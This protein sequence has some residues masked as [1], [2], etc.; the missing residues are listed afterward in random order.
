MIRRPK[1]RGVKRYPVRKAKLSAK[2]PNRNIINHIFDSGFSG[3]N[4]SDSDLRRVFKVSVRQIRACREIINQLATL[5][6]A[7]L[8]KQHALVDIFRAR[9]KPMDKY[10]CLT[11]SF[12]SEAIDAGYRAKDFLGAAI[13]GHALV[14]AGIEPRR[15]LG[16]GFTLP[17]IASLCKDNVLLELGF[18]MEQI[19]D[20]R[21]IAHEYKN[22]RKHVPVNP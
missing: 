3:D 1:G 5:P 17:H 12:Y 13:S 21:R 18:S 20:A 15:I 10:E 8:K 7:E 2:V 9:F 4:L 14:S 11:A 6:V 22:E 16:I 19:N